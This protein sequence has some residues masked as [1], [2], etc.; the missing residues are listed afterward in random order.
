MKRIGRIFGLV[1]FAFYFG[2][3]VTRKTHRW[4]DKMTLSDWLR[5]LRSDQIQIVS[6]NR[7]EV[8]MREKKANGEFF[9][10]ARRGTSDIRVLRQIFIGEEYRA[11]VDMARSA[12]IQIRNIVDCGANIGAASLYFIRHFPGAQ[13]IAIE[14]DSGNFD[15]IKRI[16]K[17]N[18]IVDAHLENKGIWYRPSMLSISTSFR[19]GENWSF[20]VQED[21]AGDICGVTLNSILDAHGWQHI[22]ILKIDIEGTERLLL[23]HGASELQDILRKTK[24]L[25]IEIH[26]EFGVYADFFKFLTDNNFIIVFIN[27]T[28]FAINRGHI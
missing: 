18:G 6:M 5:W 23:E 4:F 16:F 3:V 17:L 15:C 9:F 25:A 27:E 24:I 10:L 7:V 26:E 8:V 22:D 19:G 11:A 2:W 21:P 12:G 1:G 13:L 28:L 20:R 14:P